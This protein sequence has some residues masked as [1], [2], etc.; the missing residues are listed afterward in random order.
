MRVRRLS[1]FRGSAGIALLL[2]CGLCVFSTSGYSQT[3]PASE[4][5]VHWGV[6]W[7]Q[8]GKADYGY[9]MLPGV[10]SFSI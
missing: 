9:P 6:P 2:A 8:P 7:P 3:E 1:S 4:S 5:P 10:E